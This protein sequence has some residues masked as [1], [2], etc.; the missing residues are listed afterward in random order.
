MGASWPNEYD[1]VG[2]YYMTHLDGSVGRLSFTGAVPIAA[3][4]YEKTVDG[5]YCRRMLNV[6]EPSRR[7]EGLLN[8][9]AVV[10]VPPAHDPSH[11]NAILSSYAL[12]K[13]AL[14]ASGTGFKSR[15]YGISQERT[16]STGAHIANVLRRPDTLVAFGLGWSWARWAS[17]RRIP[18][19]LVPSRNG[20][21]LHFSAEQSPSR[22]NRVLLSD[23]R[24]RFGIPRLSVSWSTSHDDLLSIVRSLSLI[25]K[26]IHRAGTGHVTVPA[27]VEE[28][29]ATRRDGN[30][31]GGT[32][33]MGTTRMS[34]S[35]RSGVVDGDCR[36]HGVPN[37]YVAS[38]SVFPTGG[39]AAPTL[40]IVALAVRVAAE[41]AS[42]LSSRQLIHARKE[43]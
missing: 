31:L 11:G 9:T 27:S 8:L 25:Q 2:R 5:V 43:A 4:S 26:A 13:R 16:A 18:S 37:L 32:H 10:D 12:V 19:V 28:L 23:E 38:S 42:K 3:H 20:Y 36:V 1:V 39:Y 40:T 24:D 6:T 29:V 33:A 30:L 22:E 41:I 17:S 35:A 34:H 7:R 21:S 15:R 14:Y